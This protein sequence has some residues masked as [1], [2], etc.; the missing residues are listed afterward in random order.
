MLLHFCHV[1][2]ASV[3]VCKDLFRQVVNLPLKA[4]LQQI[5]VTSEDLCVTKM[6]FLYCKHVAHN[7]HSGQTANCN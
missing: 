6:S 7:Y 1:S 4:N 3:F 2:Y 5:I